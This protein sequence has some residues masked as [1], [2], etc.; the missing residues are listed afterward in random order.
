M[1]TG[2]RTLTLDRLQPFL[3]VLLPGVPENPSFTPLTADASTRRYYRLRW[4]CRPHRL[5]GPVAW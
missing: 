4:G 1:S 3:P 2:N 5:P